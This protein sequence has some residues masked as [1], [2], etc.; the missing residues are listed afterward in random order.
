MTLQ[1]GDV[2]LVSRCADKRLPAGEEVL[3]NGHHGRAVAGTGM[4]GCEVPSDNVV[5]YCSMEWCVVACFGVAAKCGSPRISAKKRL[6]EYLCVCRLD[7]EPSLTIYVI[8]GGKSNK[9]KTK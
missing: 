3:E 2:V 6:N 5:E 7:E 9:N 4:H 1:R 8:S